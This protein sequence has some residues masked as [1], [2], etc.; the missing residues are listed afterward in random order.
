MGGRAAFSVVCML[1]V[2]LC[3][4]LVSGMV[5]CIAGRMAQRTRHPLVGALG[6]EAQKKRKKDDAVRQQ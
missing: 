2:C 1:S 6:E 5:C 3:C 4:H